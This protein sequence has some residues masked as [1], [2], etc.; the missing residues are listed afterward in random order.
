MGPVGE[1]LRIS[2]GCGCL[3]GHMVT[4][5]P[6]P[7]PAACDAGTAAQT[8]PG[9]TGTTALALEGTKPKAPAHVEASCPPKPDSAQ[10]RPRDGSTR[11]LGSTGSRAVKPDWAVPPELPSTAGEGHSRK[12]TTGSWRGCKEWEEFRIWWLPNHSWAQQLRIW[13]LVAPKPLLWWAVAQPETAMGAVCPQS[14]PPGCTSLH[15]DD[16]GW[17]PEGGGTDCAGS[18]P[19]AAEPPLPGVW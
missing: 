16:L 2:G 6:H 8:L 1:A 7:A 13:D 12:A 9:T 14:L 15:K 18:R 5:S 17:E 19:A 11:A 3:S 4:R 10:G